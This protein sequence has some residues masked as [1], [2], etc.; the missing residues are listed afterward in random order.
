MPTKKPAKK[1]ARTAK[2][3]LDARTVLKF[4]EI[5]REVLVSSNNIMIDDISGRLSR[6]QLRE[7]AKVELDAVETV[8]FYRHLLA[9][10]SGSKA[11]AAKDKGSARS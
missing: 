8:R 11:T 7:S 1:P 2:V 5:L 10:L 3:N 6:K 4:E 9:S